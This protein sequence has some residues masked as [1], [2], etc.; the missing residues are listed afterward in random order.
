[1][2]GNVKSDPERRTLQRAGAKV[3]ANVLLALER[4]LLAWVRTALAFMGFGFVVGR[5]G[6][7]L[8]QS[9]AMAAE[10]V[11]VSRWLGTALVTLG[12]VVQ[13]LSL[14][15]YRRQVERVKRGEVMLPERWSPVVVL[16]ALLVAVGAGMAVYL[17]A[18]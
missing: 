15:D 11:D 14:V 6:L 16:S 8:E 7:F 5:F 1:V 12:V 3:D 10:D 13:A 18:L 17:A 2:G 4:T 9:A